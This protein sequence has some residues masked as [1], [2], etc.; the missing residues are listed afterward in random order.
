MHNRQKQYAVG[1]MVSSAE[2][3]IQIGDSVG[4]RPI[5]MVLSGVVVI[6]SM[7]SKSN[8]LHMI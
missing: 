8:L 6:L 5:G 4:L 2:H 3:C 7:Q 1:V